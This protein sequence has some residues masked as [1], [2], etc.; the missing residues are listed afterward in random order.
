MVLPGD[1]LEELCKNAQNEIVLVAPFVKVS[2]LERL[3]INIADTVVLQCVTRWRPDEIVAGVSDLEIWPLLKE[4]SNT[5]LW[6][7]SDLHAKFYRVDNQCLVGSANIT[8][9]ALGWIRQSN[10]ELLVP[11]L[12]NNPLLKVFELELFKGCSQVDDSLFN[13]VLQ[14]VQFFAENRVNLAP[15]QSDET[16]AILDEIEAP[17]QSAHMWLPT[18]RHPEKLYLAYSGN[19]EALTNTAKIMALSDLQALSIPPGL[20]RPI[21]ER[22][23][24]T[25]LLQRPIIR[26]VDEFVITPQRFG[27]VR[28]LLA[29]LPCANISNFDARQAWQTLMRWLRYFLPDRYGLIVPRHSEVFFREK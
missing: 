22:Y 12:A 10:F 19:L 16:N 9:T 13:Q 2:A 20:P 25:L 28:D 1:Q 7:R 6:L 17:S 8:L 5:S 26:K 27:A 29:S 4:R 23:V 11:I 15:P 3:L 21:F 24:G 14:V 18:L